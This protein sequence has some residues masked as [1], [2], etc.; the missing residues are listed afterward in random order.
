MNPSPD[1][2]EDTLVIGG[3]T[4]ELRK[5]HVPFSFEPPPAFRDFR[6]K[7]DLQ[8]D[9]RLIAGAAAPDS[10]GTL[11]FGS[12]E[13]AF[14]VFVYRRD[15]G[16]YDWMT[17][18]GD[19]TPGLSFRISPDWTEFTLWDDRTGTDGEHAFSVFGS[20]FAYAVLRLNACV[21]HG[22]V[23]EYAGKGILVT[24]ASGTGKTT[25]TDMWR[26]YRGAR[27]VNGDRCLCRKINGVWYAY[28]MPWAGSSGIYMNRRVPVSCIVSL[29]RGETNSVSRLSVFDGCIDLMQRIFAP[30]WQGE[31]QNRGFDCCE[32]LASEVPVL[33]LS[34][35]PEPESV[36]VL[37]RAVEAL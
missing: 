7:S 34:C 3:F 25:H 1:F 16:Y 22:V 2:S 19:R 20:L 18:N 31:L 28:G 6:Q 8:P 10:S 33:A 17:K 30:V 14:P 24:A 27:I 32:A 12:D 23:M 11:L 37:L 4:T 21:L 35:R 29:R 26:A 9:F 15:S 5:K 13:F 36:E